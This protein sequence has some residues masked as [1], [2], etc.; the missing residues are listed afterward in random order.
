MKALPIK[1]NIKIFHPKKL[2]AIALDPKKEIFTIYIFP[3]NIH[4]ISIYLFIKV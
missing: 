3:L 4:D 2:V 1:K